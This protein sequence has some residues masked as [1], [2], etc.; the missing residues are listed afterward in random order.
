MITKEEFQ[1][2]I[3]QGIPDELP[4]PAVYE[5]EINHAPIK[6]AV[7]MLFLG[8]ILLFSYCKSFS[9]SLYVPSGTDGIGSSLSNNIGIGVSNPQE[10][11]T[12]DGSIRGNQSGALRISTGNGYI[13]IGP[14]NA[15]YAHFYTDRTA[16]LFDKEIRTTSGSFCSG[17]SYLSLKTAGSTKLYINSNGK[18]GIGTTQPKSKLD[19]NGTFCIS[20]SN[21]FIFGHSNGNGVINFGNNGVGNLYFRSL[22]EGGNI[23]SDNYNQ[24][25]ILTNDGRL[26]IGTWTP[27]NYKL[28]VNG[29]IRAK[30][31]DVETGWSDFVFDS[32]YKLIT[33]EELELYIKENG[34][35]P[36]MPS[37]E[38]V[39]KNGVNV[40]ETLSKL[41]QK[42]EE[43]TLYIIELKKE[44]LILKDKISSIK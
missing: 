26:G 40:G 28:A 17:T 13:D 2:L 19:V 20:G 38:D 34:H 30:Y 14:K 31:I 7:G 25:M 16:Y 4:E 27:D 21:H 42:I 24:L 22:Q 1:K 39:A 12:I 18:V 15:N 36:D 9:Q 37:S 5:P 35:L 32:D 10:K 29:G 33:L 23:N 43:L 41:L 3:L 44:N 6:R 11:L 8:C